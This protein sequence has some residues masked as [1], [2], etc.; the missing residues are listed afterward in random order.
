MK[1]ESLVAW[2]CAHFPNTCSAHGF[3]DHEILAW[4]ATWDHYRLVHL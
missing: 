3:T 1:D 4:F 2:C